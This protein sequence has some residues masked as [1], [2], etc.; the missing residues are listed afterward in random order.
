MDYMKLNENGVVDT[1]PPLDKAHKDTL[2]ASGWTE[3]DEETYDLFLVSQAAKIAEVE[4][5]EKAEAEAAEVALQIA[6]GSDLF[7]V[8][9]EPKPTK[10]KAKAAPKVALKSKHKRI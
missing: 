2:I 10:A 1:F 6:Q 7:D 5:Q 8:N 4:A 9:Q 3:V